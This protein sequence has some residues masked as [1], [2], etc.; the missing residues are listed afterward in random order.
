MK[1]HDQSKP[2][3]LPGGMLPKLGPN[4]PHVRPTPRP[5][6]PLGGRAVGIFNH[7]GLIFDGPFARHLTKHE[8]KSVAS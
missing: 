1:E 5:G 7:L 2:A 4:R 6:T 3:L 8:G